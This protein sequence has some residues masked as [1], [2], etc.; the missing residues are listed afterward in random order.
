MLHP[1]S[2]PSLCETSDAL[3][4]DFD[5]SDDWFPSSSVS[6]LSPLSLSAQLPADFSS[7][8][9]VLAPT[10]ASPSYL[11]GDGWESLAP[12]A[13]SSDE[14]DVQFSLTNGDDEGTGRVSLVSSLLSPACALQ[15]F[16]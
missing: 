14:P 7:T 11:I 9:S 6:P 8:A 12:L 4:F 5:F 16:R 1:T 3:S 15:R 10:S 13:P 2:S